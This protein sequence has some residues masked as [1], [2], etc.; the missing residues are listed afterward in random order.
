MK[1]E[2]LDQYLH[3]DEKVSSFLKE[4]ICGNIFRENR[5]FLGTHIHMYSGVSEQVIPSGA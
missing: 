3:P 5:T 4:V 2:K 1:V